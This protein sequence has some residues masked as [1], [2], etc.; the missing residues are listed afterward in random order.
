MDKKITGNKYKNY[1]EEKNWE[2]EFRYQLLSR[3][4]CD[5]IYFLGYGNLCC[6][7]LWAGNV[8]DQIGYMKALWESFP[9]K[10]RPKWLSRQASQ[11]PHF[12]HSWVFPL[13]RRYIFSAMCLGGE[14]FQK[15]SQWVSLS[16]SHELFPVFQYHGSILF[17]ICPLIQPL[18]AELKG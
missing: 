4:L 6:K 16:L 12:G 18:L 1:L 9:A 17:S 14:L 2:P 3:M 5:C 13:Q 7:L 15:C 10:R 8:A 11:Q